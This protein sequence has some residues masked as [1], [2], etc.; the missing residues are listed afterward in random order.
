MRVFIT[1]KNC[2][3]ITNSAS[4]ADSDGGRMADMADSGGGKMSDKKQKVHSI[5]HSDKQ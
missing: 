2:Y 4:L 3:F 1:L 5:R